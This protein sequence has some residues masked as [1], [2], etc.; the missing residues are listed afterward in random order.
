[1]REVQFE[2]VEFPRSFANIGVFWEIFC[3]WGGLGIFRIWGGEGIFFWGA[4]E[5]RFFFG[6]FFTISLY[7]LL[8]KLKLNKLDF[9][10]NQNFEAFIKKFD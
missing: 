7:S 4:Q 6:L 2:I 1:M 8:K 9:D 3:F 5:N 10:F